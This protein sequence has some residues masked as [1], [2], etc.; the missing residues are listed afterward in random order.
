MIDLSSGHALP[1]LASLDRPNRCIRGS[2]DLRRYLRLRRGRCADA[3]PESPHPQRSLTACPNNLLHH[4]QKPSEE[5]EPRS[6][7]VPDPRQCVENDGVYGIEEEVVVGIH[8]GIVP[9]LA[10]SVAVTLWR[11]CLETGL[12]LCQGVAYGR[13][14]NPY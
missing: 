4:R 9:R 14:I 3:W 5:L 6:R 11:V 12:A 7:V 10:I 13:P 2:I 1:T 8:T